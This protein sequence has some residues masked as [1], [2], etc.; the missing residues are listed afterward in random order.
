VNLHHSDVKFQDDSGVEY[1]WKD[2]KPGLA[3]QV[4]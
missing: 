1:V 3:L 2:N 4:L